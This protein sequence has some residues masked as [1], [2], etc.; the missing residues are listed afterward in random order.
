MSPE[1]AAAIEPAAQRV[2]KMLRVVCR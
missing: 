1:V 2:L